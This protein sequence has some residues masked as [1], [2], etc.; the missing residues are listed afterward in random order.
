[1][2]RLFFPILL[3]ALLLLGA[4]SK[5]DDDS[6]SGGAGTPNAGNGTFTCE[7]DGQSYVSDPEK[8]IGLSSDVG[9]L[10]NRIASGFRDANGDTL[11]VT[12]TIVSFNVNAFETGATFDSGNVLGNW[13]F[14]AVSFNNGGSGEYTATSSA[15]NLPCSVTLTAYDP[16]AATFSGTFAFDANDEDANVTNV[17]TNGVFTNIEFD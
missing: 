3:G 5:D 17:V 10:F 2:K 11:V 15:D 7:V 12:I 13:C 14:G 4:C 6:S 9:G 8:V 16:V 1:M